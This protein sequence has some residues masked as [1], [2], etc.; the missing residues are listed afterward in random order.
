MND[1]TKAIELEIYE[2]RDIP[3]KLRREL[4]L[5][6]ARSSAQPSPGIDG[7]RLVPTIDGFRPIANDG[8]FKAHPGAAGIV[9]VSRAVLT[10]D[11]ARALIYV[12][13]D[14]GSWC[15]SGFLFVLERRG[16]EWVIAGRFL[17]YIT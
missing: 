9:Q 4:A 14:C 8:F 1:P 15:K 2:Y 12:E 16:G 3:L 7:V 11:G 10:E 5:A 13:H 17:H 6:N